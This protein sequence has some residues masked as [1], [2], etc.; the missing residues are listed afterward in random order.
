MSNSLTLY[1][2]PMFS[3]KTTKLLRT[4][5]DIQ[6]MKKINPNSSNNKIDFLINFIGDNRYGSSNKMITHDG[7]SHDCL[8]VQNLSELWITN[9]NDSYLKNEISNIF[10]NEGQFFS[11]LL[12]FVLY[13]LYNS[14]INVY[15]AVY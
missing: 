5:N 3:G 13:I 10:I 11:D 6:F 1:V 8:A 2:G 14:T 9:F 4:H 15:I 12:E 7:I